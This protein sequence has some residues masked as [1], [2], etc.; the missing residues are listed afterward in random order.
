MDWVIVFLLGVVLVMQ[1]ITMRSLDDIRRRQRQT[2]ASLDSLRT[3]QSSIATQRTSQQRPQVDVRSR[4]VRR[5]TDDL[6]ATGR[7]STA[8]HRKRIDFAS[9]TADD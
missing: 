3:R 5:D 7:M 1:I 8:V 2:M 4:T 9:P 6:P